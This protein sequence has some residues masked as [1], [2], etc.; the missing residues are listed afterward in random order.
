MTGRNW[1]AIAIVSV[2]LVGTIAAVPLAAAQTDT[3]APGVLDQQDM[4]TGYNTPDSTITHAPTGQP[5]WIVTTENDTGPVESWANDSASR[6]IVSTNGDRAVVAASPTDIGVTRLQGIFGAGLARK[7]YVDRVSP[8]RELTLTEPVATATIPTQAN[9]TA[10]DEWAGGLR[11]LTRGEYPDDG[12]AYRDDTNETTVG[13]GRQTIGADNVSQTGQGVTVAVIDTGANHANG[14][15]GIKSNIDPASKDFVDGGT[16]LQAVQDP[17][18]HGSWVTSAIVADPDSTVSGETYEG[19]APDANVLVLRVLDEDGSGSTADIAEAVR[20][21][22]EQ[23]AD[24]LAMSL[25]SQLYTSEVSAALSDACAGNVTTATIA[26]GNSRRNGA[27]YLASPSDTPE[28]CVTAVAAANTKAP[29]EAGVAS[30]SQL[31]SDNGADGSTGATRGQDIDVAAPGM[32]VEARVG[33]TDN[34]TQLE[35]LSGTSMAQ[36]YTAGSAA[37]T[38]E[39][40]PGLEG[41][42]AAV[43]QRLR[44]TADPMPNAAEVEAGAGYLNVERAVADNATN[45]TQTDAMDDTAQS[46]DSFWQGLGG[47]PLDGI[48]QAIDQFLSG[49]GV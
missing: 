28:D 2:V 17:N 3:I 15:L 1:T 46:R 21:A 4:L 35:T 5:T 10:P 16:G 43:R 6:A 14:T 13:D 44:T 30:F 19:V 11:G 7:S 29:S 18:G 32:L 40:E 26:A 45:T 27:P 37:L 42:G 9:A 20:Y 31:G 22:D 33:T 34:G 24:V 38:L 25:G 49:F 23:D 8:N 36:P 48:G 12:I 39:V 41:D 47:N